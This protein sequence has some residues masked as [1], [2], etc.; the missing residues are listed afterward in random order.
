MQRRTVS[1]LALVL[2]LA[3]CG[4]QYETNPDP[5]H[6]HADFA[7]W[8]DGLYVDFSDESNM[9]GIPVDPELVLGDDHEY[10]E[11]HAHKHPHLHLHD[12]VGHVIHRHKPGLSIGEF[13]DSL[14]F[15]FDSRKW[16]MFVR[17]PVDGSDWSEETFTIHYVFTDMEQVLI[18][19]SQ[20]ITAIAAQKDV[21][22]DDACMYSR[23]CPWKGDP[24]EENC[25]A[26][27]EIPCVVPEEDL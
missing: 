21:M 27:P 2:L 10:G 24:P 20:E 3:G 23:T 16:R 26:D 17:N 6:T 18:T 7:V 8:M 25:V 1:L 15:R 4:Q 11:A 5:N 14:G 22:T 13:F 19:D 9:S 12:G